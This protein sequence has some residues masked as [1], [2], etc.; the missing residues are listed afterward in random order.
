MAYTTLYEFNNHLKQMLQDPTFVLPE[1]SNSF[2][3]ITDGKLNLYC[4]RD[5]TN[6]H[7]FIA[8]TEVGSMRVGNTF[9]VGNTT[10]CMYQEFVAKTGTELT[11]D[12]QFRASN[13]SM[14]I[15]GTCNIEAG[16]QLIIENESTVTFYSDS[17]LNIDLSKYYQNETPTPSVLVNGYSTLNIYG[18]INIT[19]PANVP[20]TSVSQKRSK[21][22]AALD[23]IINNDA[24]QIDSAA[25]INVT[26]M[27][28][29]VLGDR[30][31]SLTDY[32]VMLRGK[33]INIHTQGEY[34]TSTGRVGYTWKAGSVTNGS[35]CIEMSTLWGTAVL[36]DFK[37]SILGKQETEVPDLQ[38]LESFH[39]GKGTT[40]HIAESFN[41]NTYIRPELYL[42]RII[43]N[44]TESGTGVIDGTV[45]VSGSSARIT[46]DREATLTISETGSV[47]LQKNAK[48]YSTYNKSDR[49]SVV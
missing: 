1:G 32:E 47:Y 45:Y 49:K 17:V 30:E 16:A 7:M 18:D 48:L 27:N 21:K 11:I 34:N 44:C 37:L 20:G 46:V 23:S 8:Y 3:D 9:T 40:L 39:V 25:H 42:G 4:T 12:H 28:E 14:S 5:V 13:G 22:L 19:L 31:V 41:G 24:I 2:Y 38:V 43:G 29:L 10:G 36:G 15:H 26:N 6:S 35:Q 33:V